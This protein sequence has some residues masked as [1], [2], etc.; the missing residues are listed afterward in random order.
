MSITKNSTLKEDISYLLKALGNYEDVTPDIIDNLKHFKETNEQLEEK[1]TDYPE[2]LKEISENRKDYCMLLEKQYQLSDQIKE[3]E[4]KQL[5][6]LNSHNIKEG[7]V[8]QFSDTNIR[9]EWENIL[10]KIKKTKDKYDITVKD[11]DDAARQ[12]EIL[13]TKEISPELQNEEKPFLQEKI[14]T[15]RSLLSTLKEK[16]MNLWEFLNKDITFARNQVEKEEQALDNY[17]YYKEN[18]DTRRAEV[19]RK[20]RNHERDVEYSEH[21]QESIQKNLDIIKYDTKINDLSEKLQDIDGQLK[22][23]EKSKKS[24]EKSLNSN[25]A[26]RD[27]NKELNR[28]KNREEK[29]GILSK[30]EQKEKDI[31]EK[32]LNKMKKTITPDIKRAQKEIEKLEHKREKLVQKIKDRE[33]SL[34]IEAISKILKGEEDPTKSEFLAVRGF[35]KQEKDGLLYPQQMAII[36]AYD[37]NINVLPYINPSMSYGEINITTDMLGKGGDP[38]SFKKEHENEW[39]SMVKDI[40]KALE[41]RKYGMDVESDKL[42][43]S[44][45]SKVQDFAKEMPLARENR[46]TIDLSEI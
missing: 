44:V 41:L 46:Q 5:E 30:V 36:E 19:V 14:I 11:F 4:Q 24:L 38:V 31:L 43:D 2:T 32:S 7:D 27:L 3:L 8:I 15:M 21:L 16:A 34:D 10:D 23:L 1:F 37:R 13:L 45:S 39:K 6:F 9:D 28:L 17:N 42:L 12:H 18:G 35:T 22:A 26:I 20:T 29:D 33:D 25:P 40:E